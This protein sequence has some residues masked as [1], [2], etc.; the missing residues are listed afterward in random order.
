MQL[1]KF[2]LM[3]ILL[4]VTFSIPAPETKEHIDLAK[5]GALLG[6]L[7]GSLGSL[8]EILAPESLNAAKSVVVNA[9]K[10]LDDDGTKRAKA[11]ITDASNLLTADLVK[12]L[13]ELLKEVGP[14]TAAVKVISML[15][16]SLLGFADGP[17]NVINHLTLA[18]ILPQSPRSNT[19]NMDHESAIQAA[20]D[21][22]NAQLAPNYTAT[23]NKIW[24]QPSY[25]VTAL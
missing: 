5:A 10:L 9:A 22:L 2:L 11:L 23:A 13:N 8:K 7:L 1:F 16:Q 20:I 6:D 12:Q 24:N 19:H 4:V 18:Q 14:V 17:G 3:F 15:F 21:D 25:V